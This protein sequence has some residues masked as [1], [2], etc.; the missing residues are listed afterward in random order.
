MILQ[1][2]AP[3]GRRAGG[4]SCSRVRPTCAKV[5]SF[6]RAQFVTLLLTMT[7]PAAGT[8]GAERT[9]KGFEPGKDGWLSLFDGSDLDRW[10]PA[11]GS[12]WALKGGL[13]GGSKGEV[14]SYWH[15]AD[16]ELIVVCRGSGAVCF[17]VAGT[18]LPVQA[19][20]RLSVDDGSLS[21]S[22]GRIIA[23][24]SG[25]PARDW[26]EIRLSVAKGRFSVL[27]DGKK[28]SEGS[29][30][31]CSGM[32]K[33]GLA[34]DGKLFQVRLIRVR[35]L[36]REKHAAVPSP[37]SS[38]YVCHANFEEEPISKTH[39]SREI[40]CSKCHGPSFDHRSD[41]ANVTAPDVMFTRGEVDGACLECHERH[42]PKK[43]KEKKSIPKQP[44]CTDCHGNHRSSN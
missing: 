37:N 36:N 25:S 1:H 6:R 5:L 18:P 2:N 20:Y 15:W 42:E 33:I 38:C 23:R 24:G 12:D 35:P 8:L 41:E 7:V 26:R 27:F 34:A 14:F 22:G 19:G 10:S 29:D 3:Q 30:A 40:E 44:V 28:V 39:A 31:A 9:D 16:F 4:A 32:G 11:K 17:R 13:L 21:G 43:P